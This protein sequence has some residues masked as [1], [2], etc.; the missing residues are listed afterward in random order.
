VGGLGF[1]K[2]KNVNSAL[3]AKLAWMIV[4]KRNS[5]YMSIIRAKY[6]VKDDWFQVEPPKLASPIWK[7]IEKAKSVVKKGA[8]FLIKDGEF[9]DMWLDPW[10]PW[11]QNFI[12]S[13]R[14]ETFALIP[15][16]VSEIIDLDLHT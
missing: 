14:D 2:A 3:L 13:P 16:K 9:V 4:S 12:P 6:K 10:V 8:Y 5:L 15:M 7:A 1:K 11:I